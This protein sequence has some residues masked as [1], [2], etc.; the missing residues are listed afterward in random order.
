LDEEE[1]P[2]GLAKR[3]LGTLLSQ[4]SGLLFR[5]PL[6]ILTARYLGPQGKGLFHLLFLSVVTC[7]ALGTLGLGQAS[8]YFVGKDRKRLPSVL[9]NLLLVT[10]IVSVVLIGGGWLFLAFF[11]PDVYLRLPLWMWAVAALLVPMQ[12]LEALLMQALSALLRIKE[13]NIIEVTSIVIQL[14]MFVLL[15]V[16][17]GQ[18]VEGALLAFALQ[19]SLTVTTYFLL[20]LRHGGLPTRPDPVLLRNSL[21]FGAKGYLSNLMKHL[22]FRLDAFLV[23]A[24]AVHGLE[25][26]G[27]YSVAVNL[28]EILLFIPRSIRLSLF[29]MVAASSEVEANRITSAACRHTMFLSI[30]AGSGC[31]ILGPI[32]IH[33]LYG[34]QFANAVIPLIIL[35]PG[36]ALSSQSVI[37]YG[38]FNGRGKP[39]VSTIST[40][41]S[42]VG[43]VVLDLVL[44]PSSGIIGAAV[45]S[46]CAYTIEFFVVVWFFLRH[47]GLT[48]RD[49][50]VLR[51]SDLHYYT[52]FSTKPLRN[53]S[54]EVK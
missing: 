17:L 18:G 10:P 26:T 4:T 14:L 34:S 30:L 47:T 15:V 50:F 43:T 23:A 24:L 38:D 29:P 3:S 35:L 31:A 13:I 8:I 21:W 6:G 12:I 20:I 33:S 41:V 5:L 27:I 52:V 53:P 54:Y 2:L 9:G 22:N 1:N 44:I 32:M 28:A 19:A 40:L 45:A 16:I 42:L 48:W 11:R 49:V 36:I 7:T 25:A 37:L 46:T 39:G 51:K